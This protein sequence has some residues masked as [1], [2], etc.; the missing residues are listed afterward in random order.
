MVHDAVDHRGGY[1]L[2]TEHVAPAGE[3]DDQYAAAATATAIGCAAAWSQQS[4]ARCGKSDACRLHDEIL[5]NG[6]AAGDHAIEER[7]PEGGQQCVGV[8]ICWQLTPIDGSRRHGEGPFSLMVEVSSGCFA[9]LGRS[10]TFREDQRGNLAA[11]AR[12]QKVGQL[13]AERE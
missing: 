12:V 11:D 13:L 10:K 1:H 7:C 9:Q 3:G 5:V 8:A 6:V 2:V 4:G